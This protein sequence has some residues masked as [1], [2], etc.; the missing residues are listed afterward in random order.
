MFPTL[1]PAL[2]IGIL[3]VALLVVWPELARTRER[4]ELAQPAPFRPFTYLDP[5]AA[6]WSEP[7]P[8]PYWATA[9]ADLIP[10]ADV[11]ADAFDA[12]RRVC[13][14]MVRVRTPRPAP[15][16]GPFLVWVGDVRV[17][18][19]SFDAPPQPL[20]GR[21]RNHVRPDGSV[22]ALTSV[23]AALDLAAARLALELAPVAA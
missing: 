8:L 1:L 23:A 21:I 12:H 20:D 19:G 5:P 11:Q 2:T 9:G 15:A 4:L 16:P 22:S 7:D 14:K 6:D 17:P 10:V 13:P 18:V 3:G